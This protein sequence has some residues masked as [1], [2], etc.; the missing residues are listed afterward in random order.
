MVYGF[1]REFVYDGGFCSVPQSGRIK[2]ME[3]CYCFSHGLFLMSA[4]CDFA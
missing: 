1:S 2:T 4:L 3:D